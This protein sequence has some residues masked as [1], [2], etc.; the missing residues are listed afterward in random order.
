MIAIARYILL[1]ALRDRLFLGMVLGVL[2]VSYLS[3]I[4][5]STALA[6]ESQTAITLAAGTSRFVIALGLIVFVC[7]HIHVAF[8]SRE[9]D[10]QVARPISRTALVMGYFIGFAVIAFALCLPLVA[11]LALMQPVSWG[12]FA[13]YSLS[14]YLEAVVVISFAMFAAFTLKGAVN[15]VLAACAFYV[16]SRLM[17]FFLIMLFNHAIF[18]SKI[19]HQLSSGAVDI[20]SYAVPR[21]DFF[22]QTA[23]LH[24]GA[25][26]HDWLLFGAQS[27]I[28]I[29]LLLCAT[30]LDIR[31]KAF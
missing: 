5:G 25:E 3:F 28:F 19:L 4:L 12:G 21:L 10:V 22:A 1:I 20:A 16:L 29:P 7:F 30:M 26:G 27:L 31:R 15:A 18:T 24:Y 11:V 6:E 14:L 17:G 9:M 13:A 23:W 2:A 8:D